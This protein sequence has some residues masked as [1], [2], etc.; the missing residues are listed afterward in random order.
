[1]VFFGPFAQV[2]NQVGAISLGAKLDCDG[3]ADT[4]S[5]TAHYDPKRCSPA[6]NLSHLESLDFSSL[7]FV[8]KAVSS[9]WP[10]GRFRSASV[11]VRFARTLTCYC[12]KYRFVVACGIVSQKFTAPARP[13]TLFARRVPFLPCTAHDRPPIRLTFSQLTGFSPTAAAAAFLCKDGPRA[14]A[15]LGKA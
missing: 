2:I 10:G 9:G 6:Y 5:S 8:C 13:S 7:S 4:H 1:M 11:Q 12:A 14:V 3:F 15:A